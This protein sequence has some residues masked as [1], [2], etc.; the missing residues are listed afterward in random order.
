MAEV[1][2]IKLIERL[3][4][5]E[6]GVYG[7]NAGASYS[8]FP[9]NRYSFSISFGCAPENVDKLIASTLDE[10]NKIKT[11]GAVAIDIQKFVAEETRTTET[12]LKTNSFWLSNIV[13]S[14]QNGEDPKE[15]LTY[16]D[17]LKLITPES[18]KAASNTYLSGK[19][20]IKFVL[21]PEKK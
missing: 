13:G 6:G 20:L 7:V 4:E 5:D 14:Y 10:I 12:Q 11:N 21:L 19:N 16:V 8:K 3:R 18:L 9:V 2:N 1:L 17:S 15:V